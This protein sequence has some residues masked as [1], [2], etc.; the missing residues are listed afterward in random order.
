MGKEKKSNDINIL[1]IGETGVGKSTFINA[2]ANYFT[3]PNLDMAK[4]NQPLCLIPSKFVVTDDN[5]KEEVITVGADKNENGDLGQSATQRAQAYAFRLPNSNKT[6][7]IIDTPGIADTR[8]LEQDNK[9]FE[10]TLNFISQYD[11][12]H[13]ICFLFKPNNARITVQFE[14]CI[15]HLMSRL[16]RSATK[17]I[18]FVF[19]NSRGSLY[20]PGDTFPA[21]KE[22]IKG[23]EEKSK[24]LTIPLN[25]NNVFC[26][27][28]ESFRFLMVVKNSDIKFSDTDKKNFEESWKQSREKAME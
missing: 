19:T 20:R 13:A 2:I 26:M 11:E 22:V 18:I 16:E 24:D 23:I 25:A 3:Y 5:L 15:K 4:K 14:Y 17:N 1:V 10:D 21:L 7:R 27:D 12:L 9:N 6:I 8:G 28:N